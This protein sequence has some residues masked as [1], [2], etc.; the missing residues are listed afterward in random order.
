MFN[1]D[2]CG[3]SVLASGSSK[4]ALPDC[5]AF[6]MSTTVPGFLCAHEMP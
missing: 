5:R 1:L 3:A 4:H 2:T 6:S